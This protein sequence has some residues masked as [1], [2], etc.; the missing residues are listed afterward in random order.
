MEKDYF[1]LLAAYNKE[2]NKTMN[3]IIKTLSDEEWNKKFSGFFAS[4]HILCSHLFMSDYAGINRLRPLGTY[5]SLTAE[6]FSKTFNAQE[7]LFSSIDEY[8]QKRAELD[9]II[10]NFTGEI[11][12]D[13]LE[14]TVKFVNYKGVTFEKRMGVL[15]IHSFNHDTHHR[16]MISLYLENLGKENDFSGLYPY[17]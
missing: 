4:I 14:K 17:G 1:E 2:T 12:K 7:T 9:A 6:Y 15:L 8:I 5:K 11:T 3:S 13:D 16:G 10:V